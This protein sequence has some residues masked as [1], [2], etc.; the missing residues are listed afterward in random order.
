[1]KD[2]VFL[3][4]GFKQ[5]KPTPCLD[6]EGIETKFQKRYKDGWEEEQEGIE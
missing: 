2:Q 4:R 6:S 3:D 5:F 1:M